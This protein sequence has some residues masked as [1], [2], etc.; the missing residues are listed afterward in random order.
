MNL[1]A[2]VAADQSPDLFRGR[3]ASITT[4]AAASP[5]VAS[6]RMDRAI[7]CGIS[8]ADPV[9]RMASVIV[10]GITAAAR[11]RPPINPAVR[12]ISD[13]APAAIRKATRVRRQ[14]LWDGGRRVLRR[15]NA[16]FRQEWSSIVTTPFIDHS[17]EMWN[18]CSY[19]PLYALSCSI[20]KVTP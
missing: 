16:Q 7:G 12:Q 19:R 6:A 14:P 5:A 1:K 11:R 20:R 15:K 4:A 3:A 8:D 9:E 17:S 2:V 18:F 10:A 13:V